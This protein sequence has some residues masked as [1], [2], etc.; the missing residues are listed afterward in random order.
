[1]T[2]PQPK[3]FTKDRPCSKV[4]I[5]NCFRGPRNWRSRPIVDARAVIGCNVPNV[6]IKAGRARMS[7]SGRVDTIALTEEGREWLKTGLKRYLVNN[8]QRASEAKNLPKDM[9]PAPKR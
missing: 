7:S 2:A 6:L 9:R 4:E 1:M 3:V 8:P 5:W